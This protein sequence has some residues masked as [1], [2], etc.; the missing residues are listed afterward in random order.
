MSE[1]VRIRL[2]A[3]GEMLGKVLD[4]LGDDRVRVACQDGKI[5]VARIPGRFRKKL[6]LKPGDYVIVV[7]WDFQPDKADLI[8]KYDKNEISE[9]RKYLRDAIKAIEELSV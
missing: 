8:H 4:L 3:E 6:W 5:R 1:T 9:L 7:P 2:P